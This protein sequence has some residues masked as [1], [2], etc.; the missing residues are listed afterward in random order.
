M[1]TTFPD[2]SSL[3]RPFGK[4]GGK[5]RMIPTGNPCHIIRNL[6][7]GGKGLPR[8]E[9]GFG[10][11]KGAPQISGSS[12]ITNIWKT[13]QHTASGEQCYL[14]WCLDINVFRHESIDQ[15]CPKYPAYGSGPVTISFQLSKQI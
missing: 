11:C 12:I 7:P 15:R 2:D 13:A 1:K 4:Y 14:S 3:I 10:S 5:E 8:E 9:S 6:R